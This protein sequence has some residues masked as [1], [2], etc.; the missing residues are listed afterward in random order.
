METSFQGGNVQ[1]LAV[2]YLY[3]GEAPLLSC[4]PLPHLLHR[5]PVGC[6]HLQPLKTTTSV[7]QDS[8]HIQIHLAM[9]GT[10]DGQSL[11]AFLGIVT[12]LVN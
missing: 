8:E 3:L 10:T 2:Y 7:S 5:H 9:L 6:G 1:G 12:G 4:L 11:V